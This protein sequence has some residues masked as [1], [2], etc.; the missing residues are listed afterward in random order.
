[1][2]DIPLH[3]S[4]KAEPT[5]LSKVL[6]RNTPLLYVLPSLRV[7]DT[8]VRADIFLSLQTGG[9]FIAEAMAKNRMQSVEIA[10][11][12][13]LENAEKVATEVHFVPKHLPAAA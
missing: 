5:P 6:K 7:A 8:Q 9:E 2:I 12:A 10:R 4:T 13:A 1:M 11:Q 3:S